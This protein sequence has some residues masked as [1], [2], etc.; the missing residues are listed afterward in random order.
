MV[1]QCQRLP[2]RLE[3]R[4]DRASV[5]AE[6]DDLERHA[7]AHRLFLLGH[8]DRPAPAL[9]DFLQ[10]FVTG[11]PVASILVEFAR[12]Q[13]RFRL[14][15][16]PGG[17]LFQKITRVHRGAEQGLH[18]PAQCGVGATSTLEISRAGFDR[19]ALERLGEQNLLGGGRLHRERFI[20]HTCAI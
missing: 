16:Q 5:H 3:P 13:A 4:H 1:H 15:A 17:W 6:L 11:D 8:I 9:P 18:A 7:A 20:A 14:S 2:L 12:E 10:Q 19:G